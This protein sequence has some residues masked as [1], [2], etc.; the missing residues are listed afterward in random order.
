MPRW[1]ALTAKPPRRTVGGGVR[2]SAGLPTAIDLVVRNG[3]GSGRYDFGEEVDIAMD[4]SMETKGASFIYW[5]Y[6]FP[7]DIDANEAFTGGIFEAHSTF[8][9]PAQAQWAKALEEQA[10]WEDTP[11]EPGEMGKVVIEARFAEK[12]VMWGWGDNTYGQLGGRRNVN[13]AT[14]TISAPDILVPHYQNVDT[15]GVI[16]QVHL[17][18]VNGVYVSQYIET[19]WVDALYQLRS[20]NSIHICGGRATASGTGYIRALPALPSDSG[21]YFKAY[22]IFEGDGR[23]STSKTGY[24]IFVSGW[25]VDKITGEYLKA[26][27]AGFH[28]FYDRFDDITDSR[29]DDPDGLKPLFESIQI[30][31]GNMYAFDTKGRVWCKGSN[32]G[33]ALGLPKEPEGEDPVSFAKLTMIHKGPFSNVFF[34]YGSLFFWGKNKLVACGNNQGSSLGLGIHGSVEDITPD[35]SPITH[36]VY[37]NPGMPQVPAPFPAS[38]ISGIY[39]PNEKETYIVT[40]SGAVYYAGVLNYRYEVVKLLIA[41]TPQQIGDFLVYIRIWDLSYFFNLYPHTWFHGDYYTGDSMDDPNY[42]KIKDA[43]G[44][45]APLRDDLKG[46]FIYS[47]WDPGAGPP[48]Q[49]Q[50][51]SAME[52]WFPPDVKTFALLEN[53]PECIGVLYPGSNILFRGFSVPGNS[54]KTIDWAHTH[55]THLYHREKWGC[56]LLD[57]PKDPR[58]YWDSIGGSLGQPGPGNDGAVGDD[59]TSRP[60]YNEYDVRYTFD[61]P[62]NYAETPEWEIKDYLGE[63]WR[64]TE[65]QPVLAFIT[66]GSSNIILT[67]PIPGFRSDSRGQITD[68]MAE[69]EEV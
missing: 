11:F 10:A 12:K 18:G 25:W 14:E 13:A 35:K 1:F 3:T 16:V 33:C 17:G 45:P 63:V 67:R 31:G 38:D 43:E 22:K 29:I 62:E 58:S 27:L 56:V 7:S 57:P 60:V 61:V 23:E 48:E 49:L 37:P 5:E 8:T 51:T 39:R 64:F 9:M 46:D 53:V 65:K 50:Y 41:Y 24:A 55:V 4:P 32:A 34:A 30:I 36:F 69:D 54:L 52:E 6:L 44:G 47:R 15:R 20:D 42:K 68:E 28:G 26:G 59:R 40:K 66:N 21:K 2:A 19:M